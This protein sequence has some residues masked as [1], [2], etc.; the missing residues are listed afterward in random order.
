MILFLSFFFF[1]SIKTRTLIE[2]L[3]IFCT[4]NAYKFWNFVKNKA[5]ILF[6]LVTKCHDFHFAENLFAWKIRSNNRKERP[7][8]AYIW[9][10]NACYELCEQSWLAIHIF[11]PLCVCTVSL[12]LSGPFALPLL[13]ARYRTSK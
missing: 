9:R 8:I 1:T 2:W 6:E 13:C 10:L 4:L 3:R 7:A 11:H 5:K 12:S